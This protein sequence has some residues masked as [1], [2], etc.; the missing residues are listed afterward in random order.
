MQPT[1]QRLFGLL[2]SE[3][4]PERSSSFRILT[5]YVFDQ[6]SQIFH[7]LQP[8]APL[9][10]QTLANRFITSAR[11]LRQPW[12]ALCVAQAR[13]NGI[14]A[15][16]LRRA[17]DLLEAN[18]DVLQVEK[19]LEPDPKRH[20]TPPK[21]Q[22]DIAQEVAKLRGAAEKVISDRAWR[23]EFSG[24]DYFCKVT[25]P[26]VPSNKALAIF[27]DKVKKYPIDPVVLAQFD[28]ARWNADTLEEKP[29]HSNTEGNQITKD[30]TACKPENKTSCAFTLGRILTSFLDAIA[31]LIFR[32]ARSIPAKEEDKTAK[33]ENKKAIK[34]DTTLTSTPHW[35]RWLPIEVLHYEEVKYHK[36]PSDV[37][38][39]I[40]GAIKGMALVYIDADAQAWK[41]TPVVYRTSYTP[42][43]A[44][45]V[46]P[47]LLSFNQR[48]YF[49]LSTYVQPGSHDSTSKFERFLE[50]RHKLDMQPS[51]FKTEC[52]LRMFR[53]HDER[54][55]EWV[56]AFVKSYRYLEKLP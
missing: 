22:P 44:E 31:K 32:R 24:S 39:A 14:K 36:Y 47:G 23:W 28:E 54:E 37:A 16:Q 8:Y 2:H 20:P 11:D 25:I 49:K 52:L 6:R 9:Q 5:S 15:R 55:Y 50:E 30:N 53:P 10:L 13:L 26:V 38:H 46:N 18:P 1:R 42:W 45:P 41:N 21:P 56:E 4:F 29:S 19:D 33:E 17:A 51:L 34:D 40:H 43:S 7:L 27:V 3:A 35:H 48:P 12:K